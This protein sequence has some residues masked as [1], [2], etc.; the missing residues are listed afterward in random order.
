MDGFRQHWFMATARTRFWRFWEWHWYFSARWHV[1]T[2]W[3]EC[4][5]GKHKITPAFEDPDYCSTCGKL[6]V[7]DFPQGGVTYPLKK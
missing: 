6:F 1:L 2:N 7:D 5:Q 4:W 3:Y